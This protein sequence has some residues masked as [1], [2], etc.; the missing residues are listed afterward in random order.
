MDSRRFKTMKNTVLTLSCFLLLAAS[1]L[2]KAGDAFPGNEQAFPALIIMQDK[3]TNDISSGSG[4]F[5]SESN[6]VYLVTARHVMFS[7]GTNIT[8]SQPWAKVSVY[9]NNKTNNVRI[10]YTFDLESMF[11]KQWCKVGTNH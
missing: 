9:S 5:L 7:M 10:T 11:A 1:Q 4:F 6:K 3:N 2:A 8:L